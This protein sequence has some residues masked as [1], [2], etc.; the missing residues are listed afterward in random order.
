MNYYVTWRTD[1]RTCVVAATSCL[2]IFRGRK[3]TGGV[4]FFLFAD[5]DTVG[6]INSVEMLEQRWTGMV[7]RLALVVSCGWRMS[8]V[9]LFIISAPDNDVTECRVFLVIAG[10]CIQH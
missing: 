8:C 10:R 7:G 4:G 2:V 3:W 6:I 1:V 9:L 5:V